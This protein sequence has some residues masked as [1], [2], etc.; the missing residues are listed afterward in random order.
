LKNARIFLLIIS[1]FVSSLAFKNYINYLIIISLI[2]K[3]RATAAL[4]PENDL[5]HIG[6]TRATSAQPT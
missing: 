1:L 3:T 2:F 5:T 4:L 6:Y